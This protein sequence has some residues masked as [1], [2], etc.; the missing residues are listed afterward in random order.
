MSNV[1][2]DSVLQHVWQEHEGIPIP[3]NTGAPNAKLTAL[4]YADDLVGATESPEALQ[5][6][7]DSTRQ[8]LTKWQLRASVNPTDLSKTAV[9]K[10]LGGPKSVRQAAARRDGPSTHTYH[11]GDIIVPQV[12][13]YKYLGIW[14]NNSNN[15]EEH[16][17]LRLQSADKAAASHHN[18]LTQMKLPVHLRKLTMIVQPN[19]S[20]A[21]QVWA[22]P[23][24]T[25]RKL[26]DSWQMSL[27]AR[28][29]H[30]PSNTSHICLQQELGLFPMHVT[31]EKLASR[32]RHTLKNTPSDRLLNQIHTAWGGKYHPWNQ[33]MQ[34]LLAQ[35]DIDAETAKAMGQTNLGRL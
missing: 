7:I 3:T 1:F 5:R 19:L 22:N 35:Y 18:V 20:Y 29:F 31:C 10:V 14:I 24:Q 8:A 17:T 26:L 34:M 23:T 16:L 15:W 32:Y 21:S 13:S 27:F 25:T 6:L 33:N 30:C 4:L 11:W 9:M 12:K 28:S 2:I